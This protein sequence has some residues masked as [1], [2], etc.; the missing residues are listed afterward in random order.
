MMQALGGVHGPGWT[1]ADMPDQSGRTGIVTGG[2]AGLGLESVRELARKRAS[3]VLACRDPAR[4]SAAREG[5]AAEIPAA[6][7]AVTRLDLASLESVRA[8]AGEFRATSPDARGGDHWGR[9]G[10]LERSGFPRRRATSKAAHDAAAARRLW[11]VS[12]RLTG[13]TFAGLET[14]QGEPE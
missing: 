2:N 14:R 1:A 5:V 6:P 7:I 11:E 3:V 4:G 10:V 9:D 13:V 8:F 12:E